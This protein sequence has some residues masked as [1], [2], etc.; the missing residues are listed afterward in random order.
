MADRICCLATTNQWQNARRRYDRA[1]FVFNKVLAVVLGMLAV[2]L[3]QVPLGFAD[4]NTYVVDESTGSTTVV[5]DDNDGGGADTLVL[6][7]IANIDQLVL[8]VSFEKTDST[9]TPDSDLTMTLRF[10][11]GQTRQIIVRNHF[12]DEISPDDEP[13]DFIDPVDFVEL[14]DGSFFFLDA[15][16]ELGLDEEF[17]DLVQELKMIVPVADA[18]LAAAIANIDVPDDTDDR[19]LEQLDIILSYEAEE[20]RGMSLYKTPLPKTQRLNSRQNQLSGQQQDP[21]Q[22]SLRLRGPSKLQEPISKE[23][24]RGSRPLR[25]LDR[26]SLENILRLV[27]G[28]EPKSSWPNRSKNITRS[29]RKT[30]HPLDVHLA[31]YLTF[32]GL[33]TFIFRTYAGDWKT[34]IASNSM[35]LLNLEAS[36]KYMSTGLSK[37][38]FLPSKK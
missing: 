36:K 17:R 34:M 32:G 38:T 28:S 22:I 5:I 21:N 23:L 2:F 24:R 27:S 29:Q 15:L 8:R 33:V 26:P 3:T 31:K 35:G 14:A 20:T 25:N 12:V 19:V 9:T 11:G 37:N 6:K 4:S 18:E 1:S 16:V 30:L 7:Q 10:D 13:L